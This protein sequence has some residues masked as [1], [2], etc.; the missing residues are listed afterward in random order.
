MKPH[1]TPSSALF[2]AFIAPLVTGASLRGAEE[3]PERAIKEALASPDSHVRHNTW[4]KL[5]PEND[6]HYKYLIHIL[7]TLSWHDRDAASEALSKA[8]TEATLK[9]MAKDL[10]ENKDPAVRQGMADAL[11]KMNDEKFYPEL[12]AALKDKDPFVRRIVVRNL[13][14]HKKKEAV[15]ALIDLFQKEEDPVVRSFLVESLNSITQAFKGPSPVAWTTWWLQAKADPTYELGKTDAESLRK[16]EELGTRQ[17]TRTTVS[18][19]GGV[20]LET[21]ERGTA[22]LVSVPILVLPEY[23]RSKEIMKPF[24]SELEKTNKLFYLDLP[25]INKFKDLP[26]VGG[27]RMPFYPIDKLVAA[28]EDL[29]KGT[30]QERFAIM[31]CGMTTWIAM[32][33]ASLHPKSVSHLVFIGPYSSNRVFS[34]SLNRL[35]RDGQGRKDIELWHWALGHGINTQ[36]GESHHDIFHRE[37]KVPVPEGEGPALDRRGWSLS[38]K[39][40]RDSLLTKLYPLKDRRVGECLVP[41]FRCFAE[42]KQTIPTVVIR[43]KADPFSTLEDS[44]A[45]AKHFGGPLGQCFEYQ[46]SSRMPYAEESTLFN[47]HMAALLKEKG[48]SKKAKAKKAVGDKDPV[49]GGTK[50]AP[51]APDA[52]EAPAGA[53]GQGAGE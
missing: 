23:G 34:E 2:I 13:G 24:L 32:R 48:P 29:R 28:F 47:K 20:E 5:N 14:S 15:D 27:T 4:K 30:G 49:K 50:P 1:I 26:T 12:Y 51:V 33:Y 7:K 45:I 52:K 8:A 41:D 43:G 17:K 42:P 3:L 36:T 31:A 11:T 22:G 21:E 39:D 6:S 19:T 9:K 10:R 25:E 38:F 18:V 53:R 16:A 46:S 35:E 40:E 44:R 37:K